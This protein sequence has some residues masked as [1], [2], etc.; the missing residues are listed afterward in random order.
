MDE[1]EIVSITVIFK[2][3]TF[4]VYSVNEGE[5]H[6]STRDA[7]SI[8]LKGLLPVKAYRK[9]NEMLSTRSNFLVIVPSAEVHEL[10]VDTDTE[11]RKM[12]DD[13]AKNSAKFYP[14]EKHSFEKRNSRGLGNLK[15]K[16]FY[17][18]IKEK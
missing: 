4:L 14:I 6:S 9:L 2:S 17:S 16:P 10:Y 5:L 1:A 12:R 11:L 18:I 3:P 8:Y 7:I 13:I 15:V